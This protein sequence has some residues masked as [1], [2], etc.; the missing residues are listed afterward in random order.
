M[1]RILLHLRSA[2]PIIGK[3]SNGMNVKPNACV[4]VGDSEGGLSNRTVLRPVK[5]PR[6][7]PQ[8]PPPPPALPRLE[9]ENLRNLLPQPAPGST[10]TGFPG[11]LHGLNPGP[12]LTGELVWLWI[13]QG[14]VGNV[15]ALK[16][17]QNAGGSTVRRT[18]VSSNHSLPNSGS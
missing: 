15:S 3:E 11:D 4:S 5:L 1:L 7:S 14:T 12:R 13:L 10:F 8:Q 6:Q 17:E 18:L 2:F 9:Q 16:A